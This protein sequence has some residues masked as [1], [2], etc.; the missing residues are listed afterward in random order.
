MGPSG[1]R[2]QASASKNALQVDGGG[3]LL[4]SGAPLGAAVFD[5][6]EAPHAFCSPVWGWGRKVEVDEIGAAARGSGVAG[7][8]DS[9]VA[10]E[11][12]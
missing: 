1:Q 12:G 7:V 4:R 9:A 10:R 3:F 2:F 5:E 11:M 6:A 8:P